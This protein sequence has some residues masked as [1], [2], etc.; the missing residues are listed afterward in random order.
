MKNL[1][2][3][4]T[5]DALTIAAG[6]NDGTL[7]VH[8]ASTAPQGLTSLDLAA[9]ESVPNG[10]SATAKLD[11]FVRGLPGTLDTTFATEGIFK[12][13]FASATELGFGRSGAEERFDSS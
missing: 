6:A 5:A 3:G 1:P 2:A 10:A 7:T 4:V 12:N 9:V 11:T 8:A 13:V